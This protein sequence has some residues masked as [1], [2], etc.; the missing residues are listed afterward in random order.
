[1][2]HVPTTRRRPLLALAVALLVLATWAPPAE[3]HAELLQATPTPNATLAE[4]PDEITIAFSEPIDGENAFVDLIDPSLRRVDGVGAVSV[5]AAGRLVRMT[6]PPLDPGIYT[7]TYQVVSTVDGHATTGSFAFRIDPT[8]AAAPPTTPA[9]AT[10]PSVDGLTI[11]A[12]WVALA[13]LL[14][15]FGS[16]VGWWQVR[17]PA[18]DVGPPPW[19]LV[20]WTAILAAVGVASYL[21]LAA[22]PIVGD[23]A[24]GPLPAWLDPAAP[25]GSSPFAIAMRVSLLAG[26]AVGAIALLGSRWSDLGRVGAA[27]PLLGAALAGMSV[28]GHAASYGGAAFAAIDWLHLL[29]VA[30]W[31]GALPGLLVLARRI[32]GQRRIILRRHGRVALVAAPLVALTGIANSPLVIG[33]SRDLVASD[34]GNLLVAKAGLLAVALGIGAVNHLTLRGRGRSATAALVAVELVVAAVAVSAAATLVTIQPA[35]ARPPVL[36]APPVN[37]AHLFGT[38]DGADLHATVNPPVPG[39]QSIQVS[40]TDAASGL[41]LDEIDSVLA[42]LDPPESSDA[43]GRTVELQSADEVPG[44]F[45]A[46]G[47]YMPDIGDWTLTLVIEHDGRTADIEF[48]V[49]VSRQAPAEP[50]PPPDTGLVAPAPLAAI[51]SVMPSGLLG[52]LPALGGLLGLAV[53]WRL[54][55]SAARSALRIGMVALV[56]V[57]GTG[58]ATRSLVDAANAPAAGQ[59]ETP[60]SSPDAALGEGIYL[61]NCASCHGRDGDGDGPIETEPQ[62]GPLAEAVLRTSAAE[63]SYRI[64]YGVAGTPMPAFAGTLTRDERWAL[65]A[66]LRERWATEP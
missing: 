63:L 54:R 15:A 48:V 62:P 9:T 2:H 42:Q 22:R 61:A 23:V 3:A 50:V 14:V 36:T 57:G 40:L 49:P 7:V 1:V 5:E 29:A 24:A 35:S 39:S 25:F 41:P 59:L 18:L 16:L 6:L 28:A 21:W 37:P 53:T 55:P 17:R 8:G 66:Y 31:L 26:L 47:T 60:P 46:N 64:A 45:G 20:G 43:D 58:A 52:W 12:R 65:V 10:S 4:A 44:L 19:R 56:V 34:Y 32:S 13:A 51:W 27:L 11:A 30:V 33:T 38:L